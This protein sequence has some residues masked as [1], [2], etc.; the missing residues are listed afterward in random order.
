MARYIYDFKDVLS[1]YMDVFDIYYTDKKQE[2]S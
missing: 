2:A 1:P